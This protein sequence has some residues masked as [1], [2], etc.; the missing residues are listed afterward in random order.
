MKGTKKLMLI[1]LV[2]VLAW[3]GISFAG[4]ASAASPGRSA[5]S[6]Y[7]EFFKVG[8][9]DSMLLEQNGNFILVDT[10]TW[11]HRFIVEQ[12]LRDR[13]V[14]KLQ[15][16]IITHFD[17][18]HMGSVNYTLE[19][20]GYQVDNMYARFY[21]LAELEV[22]YNYSRTNVYRNYVNFVNTIISIEAQARTIELTEN[23][24]P[25]QV[26]NRAL[27]LFQ[28]GGG[29]WRSPN[30]ASGGSKIL[31]GNADIVFKNRIGSYLNSVTGTSNIAGHV[32]NDSL[33]FRLTTPSG[34]SMLFPGDLGTTGIRH[35]QEDSGTYPI[36][37]DILKV[38]H[39]GYRGSTSQLLLNAVQPSISVVTCATVPATGE[40]T[41]DAGG[42]AGSSSRLST[43]MGAYQG[44]GAL[45]YAGSADTAATP[46]AGS[47]T[48]EITGRGP[49]TTGGLYFYSSN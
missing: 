7:V 19:R 17:S 24:S 28:D 10:G 45:F 3:S 40:L 14:N 44:F 26:Y 29:L 4:T 46:N 16:A 18:D 9:G 37:S 22:L 12:A 43:L 1:V 27:S 42:T 48:L 35:L 13:G 39:H 41:P 34:V 31:F 15:A 49:I 36:D 25:S 5:D 30:R 6:M 11:N 23:D 8:D 32:N 33:A 21:N 47:S 38:S 20:I 2:A